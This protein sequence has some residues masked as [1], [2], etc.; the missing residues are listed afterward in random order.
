MQIVNGQAYRIPIGWMQIQ[1]SAGVW[2]GQIRGLQEK[3]CWKDHQTRMIVAVFVIYKEGN[4]MQQE[5][6]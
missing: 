3:C 4:S 2:K 6:H 5:L 1:G